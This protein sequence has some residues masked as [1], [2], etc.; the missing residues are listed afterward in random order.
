MCRY[1][2]KMNLIIICCFNEFFNNVFI[3]AHFDQWFAWLSSGIK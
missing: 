1:F 3:G 2:I